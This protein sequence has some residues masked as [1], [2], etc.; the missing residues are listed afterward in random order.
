M[1]YDWPTFPQVYVDG[2]LVGG[3]DIVKEMEVNGEL[4]QILPIKR[5]A[6]VAV[7]A[8]TGSLEDQL[9]A[10][11][12]RAPVM[13]FMKGTPDAP[14]C[15]F[16]NRIVALLRTTGVPFETFDI[17]SD[18]NVRQGLKVY[19]NWPTFPQLYAAGELLGGLDIAI[20]MNASGELRD[21]LAA[22]VSARSA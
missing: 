22:A 3:L 16:S 20:E 1:L 7:T 4:T 14:Q 9:R 5:A 18:E 12:N 21:V 19:S 17:L 15:G 2:E 13:L 8:T 11:V 6:P 10:L